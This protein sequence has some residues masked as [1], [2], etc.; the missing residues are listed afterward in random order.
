M[1]EIDGID[2]AYIEQESDHLMIVPTAAGFD[3]RPVV[4]AL[5]ARGYRV[6]PK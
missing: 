6:E 1:L 5:E 3:P 4:E 2:R